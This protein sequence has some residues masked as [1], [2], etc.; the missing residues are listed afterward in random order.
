MGIL[1]WP[2]SLRKLNP[3][4]RPHHKFRFTTPLSTVSAGAVALLA[5][6]LLKTTLSVQPY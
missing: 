2:Q 1:H 6:I 4:R 5:E 3:S